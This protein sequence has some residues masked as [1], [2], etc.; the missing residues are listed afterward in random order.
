MPRYLVL[1]LMLFAFACK[2]KTTS[3]SANKPVNTSYFFDA[4]KK[5]KLP[6]TIAD[7]NMIKSADTTLIG[8]D[9]FKQFIP[10]TALQTLAAKKL[11]NLK[12][13]PVGKI[14]TE[15]ELYLLATVTDGKKTSLVTYLFD[16]KK[17][18]LNH[19]F[20]L[21]NQNHDDYV[22][23]VSINTEPT[24]LIIR[25][26][27]ENNKYSYTKN[28]YAYSNE[29]K[30]FTEVINDSNEDEKNNEII[31]PIDTFVKVNKY[32]GDY[33][34]NEKNFIS[35][36]D[37]NNPKSYLFFLHTE[38]QKDDGSACIGELKGKL[39]M[40]NETSAVFQ[41]NGDPCVIDF[42][43]ESNKV[44]VKE[45]GSCGNYRGMTCMFDDSYKK[46]T[47]PTVKEKKKK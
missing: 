43:F 18:Y 27:T 44:K 37:G 11:E 2:N 6:Y 5:L 25:E 17:H 23:S 34:K 22:H 29:N 3:V 41:Q 36:R 26:K 32:S 40:V 39:I 20:L 8:Y 24:F 35:V 46:K 31:N 4:F 15:N 14:E 10:D 21:D 28:G 47:P 30:G 42:A 13:H 7:T 45:R 1:L 19:L 38:K 9:V 33:V 12:I 16:K